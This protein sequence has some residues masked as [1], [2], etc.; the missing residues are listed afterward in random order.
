VLA[1]EEPEEEDR[2]R[3]EDGKGSYRKGKKGTPL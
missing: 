2:Q 3:D 1:V